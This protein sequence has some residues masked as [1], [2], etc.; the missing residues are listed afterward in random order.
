MALSKNQIIRLKIESLSGDGSGVAHYDGMA[1]FIPFTAP[2]DEIDCRIVKVLKSYAFGIIERLITS[3]QIRTEPVCDAYGKCGGCNLRHISYES[4][5]AAKQK[6]VADAV[7]RIGKID[8][9]VLPVLPSPQTDRYRNKVQYPVSLSPDGK[10]Y[11][12]F[13]AGRSHRVI[14]CRDCMLQPEKLNGI[15][16]AVCN[17]LQEEYI[18][19]YNEETGKG[20]VRHIFL[21]CGV[22]TD[23]IMLCLVINGRRMPS[24][25]KFAEYITGKFPQIKTVVLNINT[26]N[27]NVI[28]GTE[29]I[30]VYGSG[31]INETL[32]GVPVRLNPLSFF[33]VNTAGAELL[34]NTAK[35]YAYIQNG[36]T[37]L[38]L[39][40]GMGTIGLSMAKSC[41]Q[42][43]G[44]EII[45]Q[46]IEAAKTSALEM[47]LDNTRFICADA[48]TAA[49]KLADEGLRP[50]IIIMDPPRAGCDQ[51]AIS[52]VLKMAPEKVVMI[53]C[54][55]ATCAR[56]LAA[57]CANGYEIKVI[58]PVDM[59]PRTKHVET[60]V[61]MSK[62]QN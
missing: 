1:V 20:L 5:L 61:L 49:Q 48:G 60:V 10:V 28:M 13:Y 46:A 8:F 54:N 51:N 36:D 6:F 58:Q 11:T 31:Y 14:P 21:R 38:D 55:P 17:F 34:Y 23:E 35:Q 43:I 59:F 24:S 62:L 9:P 29:C 3:S 50:D 53:S 30:T 47:G 44:V 25:Q 7:T 4:E 27:T 16:A 33:Q 32:C 26:K 45:P 41:K 2:G 18:S 12:G 57:L 19:I 42:L 22:N 15:L 37:V 39:Y 52:A 40:C 56:D